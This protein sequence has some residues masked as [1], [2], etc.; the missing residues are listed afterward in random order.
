[1]VVRGV[2][3][4][5]NHPPDPLELPGLGASARVFDGVILLHRETAGEMENTQA[6]GVAEARI[7][8]VHGHD[9]EPRL[10]PL[11]FDQRFAGLLERD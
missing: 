7:T 11:R 3:N 6:V 1:M 9:V 10:V 4:R 2:L 5:G 8:R